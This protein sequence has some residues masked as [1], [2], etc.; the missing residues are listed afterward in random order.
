MPHLTTEIKSFCFMDLVKNWIQSVWLTK[1]KQLKS[2]FTWSIKIEKIL[3]SGGAEL[4]RSHQGYLSLWQWRVDNLIPRQ[5][6]LFQL[7]EKQE[8]KRWEP[9]Q[10]F[11][12]SL[13]LYPKEYF[14]CIDSCTAKA[15]PSV[16]ICKWPARIFPPSPTGQGILNLNLWWKKSQRIRAKWIS[17]RG[18]AAHLVG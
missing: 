1:S 2:T 6:L 12:P 9:S 8:G 5:F 17:N 15:A 14:F 18:T 3:V 7:V 16:K 13:V 11:L 4:S 10:G